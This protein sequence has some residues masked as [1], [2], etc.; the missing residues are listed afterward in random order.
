MLYPRRRVNDDA[1]HRKKK[2]KKFFSVLLHIRAVGSIEIRYPIFST[3]HH[4]YSFKNYIQALPMSEN[5][6][7]YAADYSSGQGYDNG[8]PF[9]KEKP[10][11]NQYNN[12]NKYRPDSSLNTEILDQLEQIFSKYSTL[13]SNIAENEKLNDANTSKVTI[14]PGEFVNELLDF[15]DKR[16]YGAQ[17]V[18][19][20]SYYSTTNNHGKHTEATSKFSKLIHL[21]DKFEALR[22]PVAQVIRDQLLTPANL[23]VF[24][25]GLSSMRPPTTNPLLRLLTEVI[26]FKNGEF[27]DELTQIFD[28][29]LAVLPKLLTPSKS[30]QTTKA[31]LTKRSIRY[32]FVRFWISLFEFASP[33]TRKDLLSL[34][35]SNSRKIATNLFKFSAKYDPIDLI[36][37]SLEVWDSKILSDGFLLKFKSLKSKFFN[38]WNVNFLIPLYYIS[39][40]N[41]NEKYHNFLKKLL[42]DDKAGIYLRDSKL[43]FNEPI[44]GGALANDNYQDVTAGGKKFKILN[45]FIY[46]IIMELKPWDNKLQLNLVISAFEKI[47]EL[48]PVYSAFVSSMNNNFEPKLTFYWIG[49]CLLLQNIIALPI[50]ESIVSHLSDA[51]SISG[52][53]T[54]SSLRPL[55]NVV[56]ESI[57]PSCLNTVSLT[58]CLKFNS[59]LVKQLALQLLC[60]SFAKLE[61]VIQ[62]YESNGWDDALLKLIFKFQNSIPDVSIITSILHDLE[63]ANKEEDSKDHKLLILALTMVVNYY[64]KHVSNLNLLGNSL[65]SLS[66]YFNKLISF[67]SEFSGLD[68]LL[69]DNF[70]KLQEITANS[71]EATS[72]K[73]TQKWYSF[74]GDN[75]SLFTNLVKLCCY[76]SNDQDNQL[77]S[78][79]SKVISLLNDLV[80]QTVMYHNYKDKHN[81]I[82]A[83]QNLSLISSLKF[84]A[85]VS[86]SKDQISNIWKLLDQT[87]SRVATP[88]KY[89]DLSNQKFFG[90]SPFAVVLF[91]QFQYVTRDDNY[92]FAL[93]WLVIFSKYLIITGEPVEAFTAL[94][95][96]YVFAKE[97]QKDKSKAIL[98][99]IEKSQF[100][101]QFNALLS[102]FNTIASIDAATKLFND[103]LS[104]FETMLV[105]DI[106]EI[107]TVKE[108]L[109]TDLDL[110]G[111]LYKLNEF[112]AKSEQKENSSKQRTVLASIVGKINNYLTFTKSDDSFLIL[113]KFL[114]SRQQPEYVIGVFAELLGDLSNEIESPPVELLSLLAQLSNYVRKSWNASIDEGKELSAVSLKNAWVL[115]DGSL[116]SFL[117]K[118]D[119]SYIIS[120]LLYEVLVR[121]INVSSS[122]FLHVMKLINEHDKQYNDVL[123]L[124]LYLVENHFVNFE[125]VS[126]N[127]LFA[128]VLA[129]DS[130]WKLLKSLILSNTSLSKYLVAHLGEFVKDKQGLIVFVLKNVPGD[131]VKEIVE[132]GNN[133]ELKDILA[134]TAS[135]L[136]QSLNEETILP[137]DGLRLANQCFQFLSIDAKEALLNYFINNPKNDIFTSSALIFVKKILSSVDIASLDRNSL[138]LYF[139]KCFLYINKKFA[140]T[141]MFTPEFKNFFSAFYEVLG[142]I[143][144]WHFVNRSLINVQL[145]IILNSS[146]WIHEESVLRYV[147]EIL[148]SYQVLLSHN[149]KSKPTDIEHN[150]LLQIYLNNEKNMLLLN[151]VNQD[152][153]R[154]KFLSCLIAYKLFNFDVTKN[155]TISVQEKVLLCYTGTIAGYD[156]LLLD[157]LNN[158]EKTTSKSWLSNYL[159]NWEFDD[160]DSLVY[161]DREDIAESHRIITKERN[162]VTI[163]FNKR[164]LLNSISHFITD[165]YDLPETNIKASSVA[166]VLSRYTD[167][168]DTYELKIVADRPIYD[169]RFLLLAI[170]NNNEI[171][172]FSKEDQTIPSFDIKKLVD[173]GI[174]EYVIV[175]LGT[176]DQLLLIVAQT[177]LFNIIEIANKTS[178]YRDKDLIK[179]LLLKI[180]SSFGNGLEAV[181]FPPLI[182]HQ[183]AKLIP[184]ITSPTHFLYEKAYRYLLGMP[185]ISKSDIPLFKL[186]STAEDPGVFH[187]ETIWLLSTITAGT[188]TEQDVNLLRKKEVIDWAYTLLNS[189]YINYRIKKLVFQFF[190]K[191]ND[192][193][194]GADALVTKYGSLAAIEMEQLDAKEHLKVLKSNEKEFLVNKQTLVDATELG[195]KSA[196]ITSGSKRLRDWTKENA[197][198]WAKRTCL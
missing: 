11:K 101:V 85:G 60:H 133:D 105:K 47:P 172:S 130:N 64:L 112:T 33:V 141:S 177:I 98:A 160:L 168:F 77:V 87:V 140:E 16:K 166:S 21:S 41:I 32:N 12:V 46:N 10:V 31:R 181:D 90:V 147:C 186:L 69:L 65:S 88:Y 171:L 8:V 44:T 110:T 195:V 167:L 135:T 17:L 89:I 94:F 190:S 163:T 188:K 7:N 62:L 22:E 63:K 48:V 197:D 80:D 132:E 145:E 153:R 119:S 74:N 38:Q 20:W 159:I 5:S 30:E 35:S 144:I 97:N 127:E 184:I 72:V 152:I 146:T 189:P 43:W 56:I 120:A 19:L 29:N 54:S 194:S 193:G 174:L 49:Q 191:I 40:D 113:E 82:L 91:E 78:I 122:T 2:K 83:H 178:T 125:S 66:G 18:Q 37:K 79:D 36:S 45:T 118:S 50:P 173:S 92:D 123:A 75:N 61:K 151:G 182:Y 165:S 104:V 196:L 117:Q 156:L 24:Y 106:Q 52:S 187:K 100:S 128:E 14:N 4:Q 109:L 126:P 67:K 81:K 3:Q 183:F 176:K 58:K 84:I 143:Q 57:L 71:A 96:E 158:I 131:L 13:T 192:I 164:L 70:F 179:I 139:S 138:E 169:P 129:L 170:I 157:I 162:E 149:R 150:K 134:Q 95:N 86:K 198:H 107:K 15:V 137:D 136:V 76:L 102:S 68:L 115:D 121:G 155:S 116:A 53:M 28:F 26:L 142:D 185:N 103:E 34:N 42:I 25:R 180:L 27:V 1:P 6:G 175:C 23:K 154:K 124:L 51:S 111:A 59:L 55:N 161:D 39:E 108:V 73:S 99:L 114:F 148:I 9:S 93:L